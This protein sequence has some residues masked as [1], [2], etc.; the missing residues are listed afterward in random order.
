MGVVWGDTIRGLCI[1]FYFDLLNRMF[2]Q[3]H[4]KD[5]QCLPPTQWPNLGIMLSLTLSRSMWF[6]QHL[7]LSPTATGR[8]WP[9]T[10]HL[11]VWR[12]SPTL[13]LCYLAWSLL[14]TGGF[15]HQLFELAQSCPTL[16]LE[17]LSAA[18]HL[19]NS[20]FGLKPQSHHC[21]SPRPLTNPLSEAAALP[22]HHV[23]C[24]FFILFF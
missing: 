3:A 4:L 12:P 6:P 7:I 8:G 20:P 2:L 17:S 18:I 13:L 5:G 19:A 11:T 14:K 24:T 16:C 15:G 10:S 22:H 9:P 1:L 23:Q 21:C